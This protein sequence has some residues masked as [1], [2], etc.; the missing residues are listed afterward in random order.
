VLAPFAER[1]RRERIELATAVPEG[2][3]VLADPVALDVV[4]RNLL[5]NAFAAVGAVGGGSIRIEARALDGSVELLVRDSGVGFRPEDS[6]RMF[7]K[8]TRL[9][10][11]GGSSYY[12]T[13]LGLYIVER[14]MQL[15][16]GRVSARSAGLGCGAEFVLAWPAAPGARA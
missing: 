10:P 6:T 12:G 11:G 2:L 16:G 1:A 3:Q 4:L 9:H 7:E 15:T 8:F 14:L 5:E 13:G